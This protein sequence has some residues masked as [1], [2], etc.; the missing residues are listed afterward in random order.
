MELTL[1]NSELLFLFSRS[2]LALDVIPMW[3]STGTRLLKVWLVLTESRSWTK[4]YVV[5]SSLTSLANSL[6]RRSFL[7][8]DLNLERIWTSPSLWWYCIWWGIIEILDILLGK[9]VA[10]V[11]WCQLSM[12]RALNDGGT[13]FISSSSFILFYMSIGGRPRDARLFL[14]LIQHWLAWLESFIAMYLTFLY[15][16]SSYHVKYISN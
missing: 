8:S 2:R 4:A 13:Y 11:Y 9:F 1:R 5:S 14:K 12:R 7:R 16:V 10:L 6:I 3:K 15:S